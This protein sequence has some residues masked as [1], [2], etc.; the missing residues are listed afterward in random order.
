MPAGQ[1]KMVHFGYDVGVTNG[2]KWGVDGVTVAA[3]TLA[4]RPASQDG[5]VSTIGFGHPG[6]GSYWKGGVASARFY[7]RLLADTELTAE[8][9]RLRARYGR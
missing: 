1:W 7:N 3:A 9:N 4:A 2:W 6:S 5:T 8:F